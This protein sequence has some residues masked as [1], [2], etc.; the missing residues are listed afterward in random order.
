MP[1]HI[2]ALIVILF[3]SG[4]VF[5]FARQAA[6]QVI[7]NAAFIRKRNLW[8]AI[9]LAAFLAHNFWIYI[10]V[11][12]ALMLFVRTQESNPAALFFFLLFA[13]PA[14]GVQIPGMG[15]INYFF[16]LSHQ[17]LLALIILLPVFFNLIGKQQNFSFG[18]SLP[19]KLLAAYIMLVILLYLRETTVT[20]TLRQGFYEFIDVFLPYYVISRSLKDIKSLR[21]AMFCFLVAVMIL[22]LIGLFEAFRHW[23]LYDG[24]QHV[25]GIPGTFSGYGERAGLLRASASVGTIPLGYLMAVGIGFYLYLQRSLQS[26]LIRQTG[27]LLL[28]AG[29]VVALSR[30]PWVG[31]IFLYIVFILTGKQVI[32]RLGK[33]LVTGLVALILLSFLPTGEKIVNLIPFIGETAQ[34]NVSYRERIIENSL[35]VINRHPWFGSID[36]RETPEMEALRQG[37][38]IIDIVNTYIGIAL[39]AGYVGLSL[40]VGFF[41]MIGWNIYRSFRNRLDRSSEEYLLG[42]ALLATLAGILFTIF[43]TGDGSIIPIVFWS[44]AGLGAAYTNIISRIRSNQNENDIRGAK[45]FAN[46]EQPNL[47]P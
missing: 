17:R 10:L 15:L 5:V 2:R 7:G 24:L 29:L 46:P 38:G 26:K 16:A 34:E 25:L 19:D 18:R 44:V 43:T 33:F 4:I 12:S 42:R 35:I 40:F 9:T 32:N 14:I 27:F 20:D 45:P 30:G 6:T 23:H 22:A 31:A 11:A 3:L 39:E 1:E 41:I 37:Q 36:Y 28:L 47:P 8:V 21:E 13:V